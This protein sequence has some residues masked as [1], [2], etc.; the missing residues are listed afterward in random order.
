M[1]AMKDTLWLEKRN[2]P[3]IFHAGYQ[4][5]LSV[6]VTAFVSQPHDKV[7]R[8]VTRGSRAKFFLASGSTKTPDF[9]LF[10]FND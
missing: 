5:S 3:V 4:Q 7:G 1:N 10:I 8:T 6:K 2:S 9:I